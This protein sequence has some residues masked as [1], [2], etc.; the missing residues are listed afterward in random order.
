MRIASDSAK[1][2]RFAAK[3]L[4]IV[5]IFSGMQV[6]SKQRLLFESPAL[7]EGVNIVRMGGQY[8]KNARLQSKHLHLSFCSIIV[9]EHEEGSQIS[10]GSS[11]RGR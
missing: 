6:A 10:Q 5:R 11:L 2:Q 4:R 3:N 7:F 9:S 8:R 1:S